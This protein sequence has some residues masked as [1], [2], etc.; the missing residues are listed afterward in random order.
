MD[1]KSLK[2]GQLD[3]TGLKTDIRRKQRM[4]SCNNVIRVEEEYGGR[5]TVE[6]E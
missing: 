2:N 1:W 6:Y 4:N 5:Y 3:W